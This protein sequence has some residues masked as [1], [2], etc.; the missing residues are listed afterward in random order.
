MK[1]LPG[2]ACKHPQSTYAGMHKSLQHEWEFV[3]RVTPEIG[4]S[5]RPVEQAL[6]EAFIPALF[7][8][9]RKGT[10]GRGFTQIPAKQAGLDLPDPSNM[11]P[12]NWMASCVITGYLVA[13]LM[14]QEEFRTSDNSD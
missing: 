9:L 13:A 12:E 1:I 14:G 6:R 7:H 5:F 2:V 8:S 3:Q 4:D 11:A 10:P